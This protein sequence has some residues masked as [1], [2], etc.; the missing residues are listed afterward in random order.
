MAMAR[1]LSLV[2][3]YRAIAWLVAFAVLMVFLIPAVPALEHAIQRNAV[4]QQANR[5]VTEIQ[6]ART[7][8]LTTGFAINLCRSRVTKACKSDPAECRCLDDTL[9]RQYEHGW[10]V[11]TAAD[12][13]QD[14]D[15]ERDELLSVGAPAR[16]GLMIRG[17]TPMADRL[18][19]RRDGSLDHLGGVTMVVC[20]GDES[21]T[22]VPGR[23]VSVQVSGKPQVSPIP[24]GTFCLPPE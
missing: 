15:P 11:Y 19:V 2:F 9:S 1:F 22:D 17:N 3:N 5:L 8:A 10:L 12:S 24:P 4:I 18:S 6:F 14:F 16:A 23:L 21:T 20:A 7:Q 13:S